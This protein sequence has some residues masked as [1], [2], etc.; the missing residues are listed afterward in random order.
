ML[1]DQTFVLNGYSDPVRFL[2]LWEGTNGQITMVNLGGIHPKH[3]LKR[4]IKSA[5]EHEV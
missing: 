1:G 3:L 2:P 4:Y 5:E